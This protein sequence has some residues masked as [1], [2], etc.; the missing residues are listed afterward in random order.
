MLN[1]SKSKTTNFEET[2]QVVINHVNYII[3]EFDLKGNITYIN[4]QANNMLGYKNEDINGLNYFKFIHPEDQLNI[5]SKMITLMKYGGSIITEYRILHKNGHYLNL[6]I[7]GSVIKDTD[8][9]KL[10]AILQD[11]T[12]QKKTQGKYKFI[13]ENVNDIIAMF[14]DKLELIFIN[15]THERSLGFSKEEI[16]GKSVLE[17]LHPDEINSATE[18]FIKILSEGQWRRQFRIRLKNNTY[19]WMDINGKTTFDS[20]GNQRMVLVSRDITK[21]KETEEKL[22]EKNIELEK[23]NFLKTEF[24]SRASHELKTPLVS[25]KGNADLALILHHKNLNPEVITMLEAIQKDSERLRKIINKL[26]ASSKLE[27]SNIELHTTKEDLS[28]LIKF[29]VNEVH[30]LV[31]M[32]NLTINLDL[33]NN[34]TT[35]F[36]K[37]QIHEV[38]T[39]L[40]TNAVNYSLPGGM[41]EI[42]STFEDKIIIVSMKDRGIGFTKDEKKKLFQKF[43]KIKRRNLDFDLL[44]EGSGLGLYIAK[45]IIELHGGKIWVESKG[46]NK[47]STFYFTLPIT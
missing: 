10:I 45:K 7:N 26:I 24:L 9:I 34:I 12:H 35:E 43:G 22:K 8:S 47:G 19:R 44:M 30:T 27:T 39:N 6:S 33:N 3:I 38:I 46:R 28:S 5:T 40:L 2:L 14:D 41:I 15:E 25:I 11:I 13:T 1:S 31:K 29:C 23:L 21:E 20:D 4:P 32:R 18:I 16:I 17:F 42:K 37:E 36:N